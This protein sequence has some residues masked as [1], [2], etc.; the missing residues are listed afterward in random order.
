M[1]INKYP[2]G[3]SYAQVPTLAEPTELDKFTEFTYKVNNYSD[4][5]ELQQ[6]LDAL[7]S[8]LPM[9]RVVT[10]P[11]LIDAQ[12]DKRFNKNESTGLKLVCEFLNNLARK[13]GT[14]FK[15]FHP[16]NAEVVEALI[17]NVEIIDNSEFVTYV[18][19]KL[20]DKDITPTI[21]LP[22]GGAYKWGVKLMDKLKFTGTLLACAK[23]RVYED[24]KSILKQQLPEFD[25]EGKDILIIDDIC[26]YGG[27]FKGLSKLLKER[28]CGKLYLAVSHMTVKNLGEDPV[29]NYFDKVF[30]TNSKYDS[31]FA[32]VNEN[33]IFEYNQQFDNLE[34]IKLF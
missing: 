34:I 11:N 2:D 24:G 33:I 13:Y 31:Y 26:V 28:N 3:S 30:C 32:K 12:A 19:S 5:W 7:D 27:T 9:S 14:S 23:N 1:K 16:H 17:D 4:L 6:T 21:L 8:V 29:T 18:L 22:D 10:I 20:N 25:F 15:I